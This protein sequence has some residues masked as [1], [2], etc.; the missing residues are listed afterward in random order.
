MGRISTFGVMLGCLLYLPSISTPKVSNPM[1]IEFPEVKVNFLINA[2]MRSWDVDL[3]QALFKLEEVQLIWGISLGG[4][5]AHDRVVWPH[6]QSSSYTVKLGYCFL[7]EEKEQSDLHTY[8][9]A[10]PQKIW[11]IIWNLSVPPKV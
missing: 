4:A 11:K 8:T 5:S 6:T 1:G 3:L 9:P 10:P 2:H 7:S